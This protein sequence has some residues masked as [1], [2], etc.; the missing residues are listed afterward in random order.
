MLKAC[1]VVLAIQGWAV[2]EV[3]EAEAGLND[4][5]ASSEDVEGSAGRILLVS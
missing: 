2:V 4:V 5:E 3:E 1:S